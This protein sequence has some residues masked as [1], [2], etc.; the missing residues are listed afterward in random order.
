MNYRSRAVVLL[1]A[2]VTNVYAVPPPELT[3]LQQQYEFLVA[4][5]VTTPYDTGIEALNAKFLV[6]LTNSGD[7]A[8]KAGKLPEVLALEE[9]KKRISSKMPLPEKDDETTPETV[10]KLRNVFRTESARIA[11]QRTAAFAALVPAYMAKLKALES[12]LTKGDRLAEAKEVM[13]YREGLGT[14]VVPTFVGKEFTNTLGMK[15]VPVKG[16]DVLFCIHET[17]RQD[18]AA[19]ANETT[20]AD[21]SWKSQ[22]R[23]GI[24]ISVKDD[25]PVVSVSWDDAQ[26][27]C[28]WL[29][30]KEGRKYRLP[31]D[32]EW[33]LAVGI[34]PQE[35][36]SQ[37]ATPQSR[38]AEAKE[39]F[40]WSADY[41]PKT[42]DK[43]GNYGDSAWK[44]KFPK[45]PVLE[46]YSDSFPT[47]APVM[48][49]KPNKIGLY[50]L[51]GNVWEWVED[52]YNVQQTERTL[53]GCAFDN[54]SRNDLRSG[55]RHHYGPAIRRSNI[56]FRVVL[57]EKAP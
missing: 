36:W 20:G 52:W 3:A 4:E 27:F 31:T 47:T 14:A 46:G 24:P 17:R 9:D 49:F 15:F 34:V 53:R 21:S 12:T 29:S 39:E 25:E 45:W 16:A 38:A 50:D 41:P 33:S 28:L 26:A 40:P 57:E 11:L 8:K 37:G 55:W 6:A 1:V 22:E 5:R 44:E 23:D 10:K 7:E 13:E 35:K 51:G 54:S 43:V 32:K 18:Y 48:S 19:Y 42:K 2:F 30:N 56:G